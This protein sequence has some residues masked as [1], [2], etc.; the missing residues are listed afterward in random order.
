M[1]ILSTISITTTDRNEI[2]KYIEISYHPSSFGTAIV[3]CVLI[4]NGSSFR[5]SDESES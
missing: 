2:K 5:I 4:G 3:V 1:R